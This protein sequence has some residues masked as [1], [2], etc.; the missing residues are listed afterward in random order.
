MLWITLLFIIINFLFFEIM[1]NF[2]VFIYYLEQFGADNVQSSLHGLFSELTEIWYYSLSVLKLNEQ[3]V[4]VLAGDSGV[5]VCHS[6]QPCMQCKVVQIRLTNKLNQHLKAPHLKI[7]KEILDVS[8]WRYVLPVKTTS[9]RTT[10]MCHC[11]PHCKQT[12]LFRVS[13]PC[14]HIGNVIGNLEM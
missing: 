6:P 8:Y 7:P 4:K 10:E 3:K 12:F 2:A 5:C 1:N 14:T 13:Q 11:E 9:S